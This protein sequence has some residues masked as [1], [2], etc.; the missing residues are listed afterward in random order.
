ME[1]PS[2][3]MLTV[4]EI[5]EAAGIERELER[6]AQ[7]EGEKGELEAGVISSRE[8]VSLAEAEILKL[9]DLISQG[10]IH[11][12]N[13][14]DLTHE[15]TIIREQL[16]DLKRIPELLENQSRAV[17]QSKKE[18]KAVLFRKVTDVLKSERQRRI[19]IMKQFVSAQAN[20]WQNITKQLSGAVGQGAV[21]V[22]WPSL[23]QDIYQIADSVYG[24]SL[25]G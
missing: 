14:D 13:V 3:K 4:E 5:K 16:S 17:E 1:K 12:E 7:L 25:R 11:N 18:I 8:R 15:R 6:L 23:K 22:G 19:E 21:P 20:D 10:L 24:S 9:N 2:S